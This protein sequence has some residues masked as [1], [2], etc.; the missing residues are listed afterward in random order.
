[1]GGVVSRLQFDGAQSHSGTTQD[2]SNDLGRLTNRVEELA[3]ELRMLAQSEAPKRVTDVQLLIEA[4]KIYRFRRQIDE[5]FD[6]DGF[7]RSPAWDIMLDLI[8]ANARGRSI[9]VSS[10]GI[11]AACPGTTALRWIHALEGMGLITRCADPSDKRRTM[12]V[13]TKDGLQKTTTALQARLRS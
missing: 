10:A 12:V 5:I 1:M 3:A 11:G 13:L 8:D 6:H 7:S 9:S 2:S 4:K